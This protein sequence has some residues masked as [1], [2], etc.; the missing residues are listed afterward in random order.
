MIER[1]AGAF[2]DVFGW[3]LLAEPS[4]RR[5]KPARARRVPM[6]DSCAEQCG[7]SRS[8]AEP[9]DTTADSTGQGHP[10]QGL[11]SGDPVSTKVFRRTIVVASMRSAA[12]GQFPKPPFMYPPTTLSRVKSVPSPA[13]F[14]VKVSAASTP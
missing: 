2:A 9:E 13:A 11:G 14:K 10:S 12:A 8:A 6:P 7:P 4:L 5:S 3:Q 1:L